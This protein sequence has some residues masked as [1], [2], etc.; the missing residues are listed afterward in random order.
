[1]DPRS[2]AEVIVESWRENKSQKGRVRDTETT[3]GGR[4]RER[5]RETE[6]MGGGERERERERGY[7][8]ER[9]QK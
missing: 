9:K 7:M 8:E 4:E 2:Y 3:N 6:N 1:M 5:E